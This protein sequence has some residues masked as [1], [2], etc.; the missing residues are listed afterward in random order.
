MSKS[1]VAI[2]WPVL[3]DVIV[4]LVGALVGAGGLQLVPSSSAGAGEAAVQARVL[5]DLETDVA[6]LRAS[7]D[8][9]VGAL[10]GS[11]KLVQDNQLLICTALKVEGCQ[12]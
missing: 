11:V 9:D 7:H 10:Q 1:T 5:E 8:A 3:R 2:P 4:L 6:A 12:R